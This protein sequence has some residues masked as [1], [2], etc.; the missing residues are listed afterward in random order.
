VFADVALASAR[1]GETSAF[2]VHPALCD[3]I[4]QSLA[5]VGYDDGGQ[6]R[7]PYSWHGVAIHATGATALR[8]RLSPIGTDT[9][10]VLAVDS[11][12][13]P[14]FSVAALRLRTV[15][16]DQPSVRDSAA[17]GL[18]AV[19]LVPPTDEV[20]QPVGSWAALGDIDVR[21]TGTLRAAWGAGPWYPDLAGLQAALDATTAPELVVVAPPA[22]EADLPG[23][24]H[25]S[26]AAMLI[27]V[28]D[29]L[30]DKRLAST[31]LMVLT[32]SADLVDAAVRGLVRSAQTEHPGRLVLVELDDTEASRAALPL[33]AGSAEP[34]LVLR[35][36]AVLLP[37]LARLAAPKQESTDLDPQGT[38]VVT[39]A[40]GA[41]GA[42]VARYLVTDRGARRLLLLSR[43]G[44]AT[45]LVEE[46]RE[47][48]AEV[49]VRACDVADRAALADAL[50][51]IPAAHPLTGVVHAA[52]TLADATIDTLDVARLAEV[53]RP[54]VDA[55]LALHELTEGADLR[56][57]ALF[58]SL[59]GTLGA[60]GQAN[61]A[62]GNAFLDALAEHRRARGLAAQSL[63]WG[64]WDSGMAR[65]G[66]PGFPALSEKDGLA[67]L[68][69]AGRTDRAVVVPARLDLRVLR[70]AFGTTERVPPL[71]RG[72]IRLPKARVTG[73]ADASA[74]LR[75]R[76]ADATEAE[77]QREILALVREHV[78]AVLGHPSPASVAIDRGFLDLGLDSL[79]GV[80]LRNRLDVVTGLRL[81]STMIFD[82]PTPLRLVDHVLERLAPPGDPDTGSTA[83]SMAVSMRHEITTMTAADLIKLALG[84]ERR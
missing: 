19:D 26:V 76:L 5:F 64:A 55:A 39:G 75:A 2:L 43:R 11:A 16:S 73:V 33:L 44:A 38:V 68:D 6:A 25:T 52:G 54:K 56:L 42:S 78:A 36:G 61:Y 50:A 58:S 79:T 59:A 21:Q 24:V 34:Q 7:L 67:L 74:A 20:P 53:L 84:A 41:L 10:S 31:T 1:H 22:I 83:K 72:L 13:L 18:F 35:N 45:E 28:Q 82:Y 15:A 77:R 47:L 30:A 69:L 23:A 57:F 66:R 40:S 32:R 62:A 60:A 17:D 80:E 14:V 3:A 12:G 4:V 71:L 63:A 27:L 37:R 81:P 9:F 51:A 65:T 8:V 48:G 70:T 29:W 49:S 46:L